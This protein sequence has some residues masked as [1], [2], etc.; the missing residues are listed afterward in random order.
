MTASVVPL[1]RRV[2]FWRDGVVSAT[3]W[4]GSSSWPPSNV[5]AVPGCV[6]RCDPLTNATLSRSS[7]RSVVPL[8]RTLRSPKDHEPGDCPAVADGE[9]TAAS[10]PPAVT[11]PSGAARL[12]WL[13]PAPWRA[14]GLR[15]SGRRPARRF[16]AVS[17]I[18]YS[19]PAAGGLVPGQ[20][21]WGRPCWGRPCWGRPC[22]GRL[23]E[24]SARLL[25]AG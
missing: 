7:G 3:G 23:P 9:C 2:P 24:A 25:S 8:P 10:R 16:S 22:W 15:A 17:R 20:P 21:C 6:P 5:A 12:G 13:G 18:R 1:M 19:A 14:G 11:A 4:F